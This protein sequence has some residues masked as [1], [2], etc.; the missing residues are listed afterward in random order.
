MK[1]KKNEKRLLIA[2]GVVLIIVVIFQLVTKE[3]KAKPTPAPTKTEN[4]PKDAVS[5]LAT[6]PV[7]KNIEPLSNKP[8]EKKIFDTWG[9]NP[10]LVSFEQK[11][12]LRSETSSATTTQ[13][14]VSRPK[15]KFLG[16]FVALGK[17]YALIDDLVIAEGEVEEG[18]EVLDI[19]ENMV[20]CREQG[21]NFTLY[22]SD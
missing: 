13:T 11:K 15:H 17:K 3:K 16:I 19:Q 8:E 6:Q 2:L 22:W 14:T 4:V 5:S 21:R 20:M 12:T 7:Q 1:L 18:I 9:D 10:F